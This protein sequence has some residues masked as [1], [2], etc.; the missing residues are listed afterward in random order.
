MLTKKQIMIDRYTRQ[1]PDILDKYSD[2]L[3][4]LIDKTCNTLTKYLEQGLKGDDKIV[5]ALFLRNAIEQ[6][7]GISVMLK[8]SAIEPIKPLNRVLLENMLQLEYIVSDNITERSYA[9]LV[10]TIRNDLKN[11]LKLKKGTKENIVFIGLFEK[12]SLIKNNPET[13]DSSVE[14]QINL[15][16]ST[17]SED[18]Y[19]EANAEYDKLKNPHWYA[20]Y[21][22]PKNIREMAERQGRIM[23]YEIFYRTLSQNIHNTDIFNNKVS[24]NQSDN[25]MYLLH[26]RNPHEAAKVIKDTINFLFLTNYI[27]LEKL[28]PADFISFLQWYADSNFRIF[29]NDL[30]MKADYTVIK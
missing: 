3:N 27:F 25:L 23:L 16:H 15:F 10:G 5:P 2:N 11:Y 18:G 12:D 22:G 30:G 19:K 14:K 24:V 26:F 7:D 29:F 8:N 4:L 28:F 13:D 9:F 21:G 20:L 17:L 6:A 1:I